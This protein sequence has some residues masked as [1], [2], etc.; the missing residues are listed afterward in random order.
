MKLVDKYHCNDLE[1]YITESN[2]YS[3]VV[4]SSNDPQ[5]SKNQKELLNSNEK[6][7]FTKERFFI[8]DDFIKGLYVL[9]KIH[10]ACMMCKKLV[11]VSS[12]KQ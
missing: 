12:N 9:S 11:N 10:E 1:P 2:N 8:Y 7:Y 4:N 3:T 5:I 6:H